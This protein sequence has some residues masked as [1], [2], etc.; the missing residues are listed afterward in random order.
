M[1]AE[2][3]RES[4]YPPMLFLLCARGLVHQPGSRVLLDALPYALRAPLPFDAHTSLPHIPSKI[5][6]CHLI[7]CT[8]ARRRHHHPQRRS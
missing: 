4:A 1:P 6:S 3:E 2:G 8:Q 7:A 5:R